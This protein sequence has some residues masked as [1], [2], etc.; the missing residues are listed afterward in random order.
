AFTPALS[1]RVRWFAGVTRSP[2]FLAGCATG[3]TDVPGMIVMVDVVRSEDVAGH[4]CPLAGAPARRMVS[5][6]GPDSRPHGPA[7]GEAGSGAGT[8]PGSLGLPTAPRERGRPGAWRSCHRPS[9]RSRHRIAV[10][11]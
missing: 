4:G 3:L 7:V 1:T 10:A 6:R 8:P 11:W 2:L 9:H 5:P